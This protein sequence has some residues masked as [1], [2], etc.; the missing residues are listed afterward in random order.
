MKINNCDSLDCFFK[1]TRNKID[2]ISIPL[3]KETIEFKF[4]LYK[5][6]LNLKY[7]LNFN[8]NK[9]QF[10]ALN[11]YVKEKPFKVVECDKNIGIGLISHE[12]Y[13]KLAIDH[14][15]KPEFY[16]KI[17]NDPLNDVKEFI[18]NVL[19]ELCY[20]KDISKSLLKKLLIDNGQL[21][22]FRVLT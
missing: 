6:L 7:D 18:N 16:L 14:L 3:Q 15:N 5:N 1:E 19:R 17:A 4:E 21:G 20:R 13:N 11:K 10:S 9:E 12:N 22:N 2:P 8:L